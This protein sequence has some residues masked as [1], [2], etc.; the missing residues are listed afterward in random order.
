[1]APL[2]LRIHGFTLIE[3]MIVV[4]VI[5]VIMLLAIPS[6]AS[7]RQ[8]AA[9]R[10]STEQA[11]GFWNQARFE[12]AKRNQLVKVGVVSSGANYCLGADTTT[13]P[14]DATPCNCFTAGACDVSIFPADPATGQEEWRGVTLIGTPTLGTNTGVAVIEPKRTGLTSSAMAGAITFKGPAGRRDYRVNLLVDRYGRAVL[15]GSNGAPD[16]MSDYTS[17]KCSP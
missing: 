8:R 2:S 1:M 9:L 10:G 13:D 12:A 16:T 6:F 3:L 11:V 4:T 15:C 17:R 14:A 7:F 5:I